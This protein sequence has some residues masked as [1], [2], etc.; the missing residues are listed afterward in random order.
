MTSIPDDFHNE[1]DVAK[2]AQ[3]SR[4]PGWTQDEHILAL[5]LYFRFSPS[6]M[7]E[8]HSSVVELSDLLNLLP[9]HPQAL[10][11][12]NFR[13]PNSVYMKLCNFLR[14]DPSYEGEGL[15]A[16]SK[17]EEVV[18]NMYAGNR[19]ELTKIV[20]AIKASGKRQ[21][22][23]R[24]TQPLDDD[25]EAFP[26]GRVLTREHQTRERNRQLVERKKK[27]VLLAN[28]NPLGG[29]GIDRV[30][31]RLGSGV[32]GLRIRLLQDL[33]RTRAEICRMPPF[34]SVV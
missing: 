13:N 9:I 11:A 27:A 7:D 12:A 10:R 14:L 16:G 2:G 1:I 19:P 29:F 28:G 31:C 23:L 20:E 24:L 5:D 3:T 32:R 8:K 15:S 26:E 4:N 34:S 6:K 17:G 30:A 21:I 22:S 18:W 25:D 33:R